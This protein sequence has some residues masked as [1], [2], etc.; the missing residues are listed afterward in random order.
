MIEDII[1]PTL[2]RQ[3][4]NDF[5]YQLPNNGFLKEGL[6]SCEKRY[7]E[8]I[9]CA[10]VCIDKMI[11]IAPWGGVI[12]DEIEHGSKEYYMKIKEELIQIQNE[13]T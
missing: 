2:A 7:N 13:N 6:L 1:N 11:T 4:I 9:I 12:D 3:L 10:L 5:Y 8:A